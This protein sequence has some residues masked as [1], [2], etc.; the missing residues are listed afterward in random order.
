M[1]APLL[2]D[3]AVVFRSARVTLA[4]QEGGESV[5]ATRVDVIIAGH[6]GVSAVAT[7]Q[8]ADG[9]LAESVVV[10]ALPKIPRLERVLALADGDV[11]AGAKQEVFRAVVSSRDPGIVIGKLG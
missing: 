8:S 2:S 7:H 9:L 6:A 4:E 1:A 11:I 3:E 10:D 5:P